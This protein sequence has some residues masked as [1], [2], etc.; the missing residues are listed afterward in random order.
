M[1]MFVAAL[2][3]AV[4]CAGAAHAKPISALYVFGDSNVDIGRLDAELSGN[5]S[6]GM[7]APPNTVAG[8][9]SDGPLIVEYVADRLGITQQNYAWGGAT[10]GTENIVGRV[11]ANTPDILPTGTL[12]QVGE[13]EAFLGGMPADPNGL[14]LVWAGS[15]D[16]FFIDKTSQAENTAAVS[17]AVS[18]I[19]ETV[20][21]LNA[22]GA[23][24]IVVATRATRP[25]LSSSDTPWALPDQKPNKRGL[26]NDE[27]NDASGNFLNA[28]IRSLVPTL[29]STVDAKVALFDADAVIRGIIAGAGSNG[30]LP[31]DDSPSGYC[32]NNVDCSQL[33]N[34]DG[35]HKTSAVHSVMADAFIDQFGTYAVPLP[36]G[37][38]LYLGALCLGAALMRRRVA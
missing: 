8:R 24:H 15:N 4:T 18:N 11:V 31:Y 1:K 29:N 27:L 26:Q 20:E 3:A 12:T 34:Y 28:A 30:F 2:A 21:R 9:S 36:A 7:V 38:A 17:S 35:A 19:T 33:I 14:Y 13:F 25:V 10:T 22:A 23:E 16:L 5:P 37:G 6:D 32:I